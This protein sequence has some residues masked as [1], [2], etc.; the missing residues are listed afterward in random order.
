MDPVQHWRKS[1]RERL[2][3]LD[4]EWISLKELF[5]EFERRIPLHEAT[6]FMTNTRK[7]TDV[8]VGKMRWELFVNQLAH[9]QIETD[10]PIPGRHD[11]SF[12]SQ[13]RVLTKS[14]EQCGTKCLILRDRPNARFCK[15]CG[16]RQRKKSVRE[17]T[18]DTVQ[19]PQQQA[20][21]AS[22]EREG[23]R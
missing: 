17:K 14:C 12:R 3:E 15:S 22:G 23:K 13:L 18:S 21:Q 1:F 8:A 9:Y 19:T 16:I 7:R 11:F 5:A 20:V 2:K 4:D 6:R 10:S